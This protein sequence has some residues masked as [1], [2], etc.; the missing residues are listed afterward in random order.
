MSHVFIL[1]C[2]ER[3]TLLRRGGSVQAVLRSMMSDV[4]GDGNCVPVATTA[5][6]RPGG[7]RCFHWL[8]FMPFVSQR[9]GPVAPPINGRERIVVL[10]Q[11]GVAVYVRIV[12]TQQGS[13]P[14]LQVT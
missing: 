7:S 14:F 2:L 4:M 8:C 1:M 5:R 11:R 6:P 10:N 12:Y 13:V 3:S 9:A